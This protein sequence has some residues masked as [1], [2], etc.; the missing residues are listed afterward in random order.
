M[1]QLADILLVTS[2][3]LFFTG[4][5]VGII[6]P[7]RRALPLINKK[8]RLRHLFIGSLLVFM[9]S[10]ATGWQCFKAGLEECGEPIHSEETVSGTQP[11]EQNSD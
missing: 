8:L 3:I 11:I 4:V 1:A 5:L 6:G 9:V 2:V 10:F 7:L